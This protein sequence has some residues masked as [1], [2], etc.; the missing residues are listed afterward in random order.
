MTGGTTGIGFATAKLLLEQGARVAISGQNQERL[1]EAVNQLGT[2]VLAIRADV[3]KVNEIETMFMKIKETFGGLNILFVNAGIAK[4]A[5]MDA[6]EESMIDEV[7]NI[8]FKGAFFTI[9]K[10][11]SIMSEGSS[12]VVNTSVNNQMGMMGSSVYGASKAAVRSLVRTLGAELIGR[13]IRVNAVSP[14]PV[15]TPI[16]GKLG[17]PQEQ[18][19][20]FATQLQQKIPMQ[21]FGNPE[22]IAKSVLFLAS[23]DSSFVLGEELVVDGGW[24]EI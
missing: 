4:L 3:S 21:R 1:N 16:Y 8:N 9:Q 10:A 14:G 6:V 13:G 19:Q 7:F 5:P 15:Q 24:T 2:E 11:A 23:E 22:E 18:L 17:V 12:I 20:E